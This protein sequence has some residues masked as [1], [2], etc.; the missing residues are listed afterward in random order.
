MLSVC[1]VASQPLV[2]SD[3]PLV[4]DRLINKIEK[5]QTGLDVQIGD[6]MDIGIVGENG[7]STFIG[8]G[9]GAVS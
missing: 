7:E 3:D 9:G 5:N 6:G 4:A 8:R 1:V 2:A